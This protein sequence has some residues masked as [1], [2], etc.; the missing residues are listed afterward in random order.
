MT[1]GLFITLEGGEGAGKS[2]LARGLGE[3]LCSKG[4]EVVLTREPGGSPGADEIRALLL[5]GE[6]GRWSAIEEA[7]LYSTARSNHLNHLVRPALGRGAIVVC[8]RYYDSTRAYQIAAGGLD[9]NVLATLNAMIEAPLPDV[10]LIL[11]LDPQAGVGR[12]QGASAGEDRFE[13]K[14]ADY[15]ARV[16]AAFQAIA[17]AEP[18]RCVLIDAGQTPDQVLRAALAAVEPRL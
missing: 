18:K 1:K 14:G 5:S 4:R 17:A 11:D 13:R 9:P 12:S 16:R 7:L 15:H 6:P 8:D 2:T 10:T 3:A